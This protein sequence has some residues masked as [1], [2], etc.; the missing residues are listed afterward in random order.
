MK[1]KICKHCGTM[2]A[3]DEYTSDWAHEY[4]GDP[5]CID[6]AGNLQATWAEPNDE[7]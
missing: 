3:Y 6:L 1:S 4:T 5:Q 7:Q 2:I